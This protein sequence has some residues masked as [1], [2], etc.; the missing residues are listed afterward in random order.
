MSAPMFQRIV[1]F[2]LDETLT[3][4]D[5]YPAYVLGYL[6]RRPRRWWRLAPLVLAYGMHRVGWRDNTWLKTTFLRWVFE[7]ENPAE[8]EAW[9]VQFVERVAADGLRPMARTVLD[10]HRQAGDLLWLAS[11][12]LDLY[13]EPLAR[14]LGIE[15]VICSRAERDAAGR[16]SGRL[17]GENCYGSGKHE[18]VRRQL[19]RRASRLPVRFYSDHHSDLALLLEVDEPVAVNPTPELRVAAHQHGIPIE[20]W[21]GPGRSAE[22]RVSLPGQ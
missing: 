2:D 12:S 13:V 17:V 4:R 7:G 10:R 19:A 8:I 11:A 5:T 16:V 21:Q 1:L 20:D 15:R 9:T 6:C 18:R 22:G 3:R 14:R